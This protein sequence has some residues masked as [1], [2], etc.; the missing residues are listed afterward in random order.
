VK[1]LLSTF[2]DGSGSIRETLSV[3]EGYEFHGVVVSENWI[4]PK[5]VQ[6]ETVPIVNLTHLTKVLNRMGSLR[7][8]SAWLRERKYLPVEGVHFRVRQG[9]VRIG[10]HGVVWWDIEPLIT[11]GY[12]PFSSDT[13][14]EVE[15]SEGRR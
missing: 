11:T 8:V 5:A 3:A 6:D 14:V 15:H 12:D 7:D 4:G 1:A 9:E 10:E 13:S 2:C